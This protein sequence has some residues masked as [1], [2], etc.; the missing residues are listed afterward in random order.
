MNEPMLNPE[1]TAAQRLRSLRRFPAGRAF[2]LGDEAIARGAI[3]G[4]CTFF[5]GYPITPASESAVW[6][7]TRLKWLNL[8]NHCWWTWNSKKSL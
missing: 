4:G 7:F 3:Y 5:A 6:I 2:L 1:R 8:W